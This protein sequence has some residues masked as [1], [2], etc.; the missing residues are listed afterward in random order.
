MPDLGSPG[1]KPSNKERSMTTWARWSPATG[2]V[3]VV[4]WIIAF[5][6][7]GGSPDSGSSDA[8]IV[9]YY[10]DSGH[11]ARDLAGLFLILAAAVLFICF[12]SALRSRLAQAEG[13]AG[14]LTAAAFA[15]GLVATALWFVAI[16]VFVSP[17]LAR[18]DT[19]KFQLDPDTFRLVND[20]GYAIWFGGTT[21]AVVLVAATAVLSRRTG[22]LPTWLTWLS[23]VVAATLLVAFLFIP[24]LIFLGWVLVVSSVLVSKGTSEPASAPAAV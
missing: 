11:R 16:V 1:V 9:A 10:A 19:S 7:T 4:L 6:I 18:G 22:L 23:F 2:I 15:S 21:I 5:A 3:Y 24:I 14:P 13:R 8:K 20:L 12:L 17:S